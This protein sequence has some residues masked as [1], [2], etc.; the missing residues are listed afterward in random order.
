MYLAQK[1]FDSFTQA[2]LPANLTVFDMPGEMERTNAG[3]I[4][5]AIV[6]KIQGSEE[7][8]GFGILS[9]CPY[10]S[11]YL[12]IESWS[13]DRKTAKVALPGKLGSC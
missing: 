7:T 3:G 13:C 10:H 5:V 8:E 1:D 4:P 9:L 2:A 6:S 12:G 11:K